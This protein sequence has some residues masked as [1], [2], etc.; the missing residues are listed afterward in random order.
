MLRVAAVVQG[1]EAVALC[2]VAVAQVVETATGHS[3]Q[4][5]NGVALA[6]TEFIT[7]A[8]IAW[9]ASGIARIRPWSRTPA[10]MTQLA[11]GVLAIIFLQAHR[12]DW[13]APTLILAIVGLAGLFHPASLKALA[14]PREDNT[15][16]A[17]NAPPALKA[18]APSRKA[19]AASRRR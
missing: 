8:L 17:D 12:A 13:G 5:S 19:S 3:Y 1:L 15:P 16:P 2:V 4:A 14:R 11:G 18:Q 7:V 6:A 10:V 9:I